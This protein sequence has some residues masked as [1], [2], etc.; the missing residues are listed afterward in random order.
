MNFIKSIFLFVIIGFVC[1]ANAQNQ[2]PGDKILAVVGN[3][4]ILE[5]DFNYQLYS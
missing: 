1:S 2:N 5:S 3:D 4:I